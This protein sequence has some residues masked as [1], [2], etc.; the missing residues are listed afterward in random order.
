VF[1]NVR[2]DA[3]SMQDEVTS[4]TTFGNYG[5]TLTNPRVMEFALIYKF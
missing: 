3:F 5:S 2:F 1:N 4:S